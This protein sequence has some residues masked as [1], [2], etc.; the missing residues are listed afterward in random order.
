VALHIDLHQPDT[1]LPQMLERVQRERR[2]F[3]ALQW[4]CRRMGMRTRSS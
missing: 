3:V 2:H 1:A 4:C